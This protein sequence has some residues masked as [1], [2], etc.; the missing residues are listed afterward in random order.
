MFFNTFITAAAI[1]GA[2]SIPSS[3]ASPAPSGSA[4]PENAAELVYDN[5]TNKCYFKVT[6]TLG[7]TGETNWVGYGEIETLTCRSTS[8]FPTN[9]PV[10]YERLMFIDTYEKM[11]NFC[12]DATL[13]FFY[14]WDNGESDIKDAEKNWLYFENAEGMQQTWSITP[15]TYD[16]KGFV[17]SAKLKGSSFEHA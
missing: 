6:N 17:G 14:D 13:W 11:E 15:Q 2:Q 12:G 3:N 16:A 10:E 9:L 4:A 7:C 5:P 1:I 8:K